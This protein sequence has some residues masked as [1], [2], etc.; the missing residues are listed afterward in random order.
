MNAT[1]A[2]TLTIGSRENLQKELDQ[3]LEDIANLASEG[4]N[5]I[6][7]SP[8]TESVIINHLVYDFGF[9]QVR[10]ERSDIEILKI[11]W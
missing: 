6:Y 7:I 3:I 4:E 2:R 10:E 8:L 1:Q 9:I 5:E 11:T